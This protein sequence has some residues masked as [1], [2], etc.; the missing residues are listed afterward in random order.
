[1]Q[2]ILVLL[3]I[4]II[5]FLLIFKRTPADISG[6]VGWF[7][8]A[9]I[10]GLF[11]E[12]PILIILK[13][14]FSGILASLPIALVVATSILQVTI[15]QEA[16]AIDRVVAL[17]KTISPQ[18][19]TVQIMI[20]NIGF[21]TLL[22]ALGAVPVSILPPIMLAMGY[23][24]F[25]AIALP[26]LGYDALCTYA[27]LGIPV[28]VFSGFVGLPVQEAGMFFARFMPIIS[29]C[30][31]LG[32]L[33]IVGRWKLLLKGFLPAVLSGLTAGLIAIGMNKI[34]LV[35]LTGI[36]AG[37]GVI[38]IMILYLFLTKQPIRDRNALNDKDLA[39]EKKISL[40]AAISPWLALTFFSLIVNAPFLP[41]F[42]LFFVD[43]AM[44]I[45]IIPGEPEKIR[46][47]WQAYF[48]ILISTLL[49]LPFL[50]LSKEQLS[51]SITTWFKRFP[52]PMLSAAIFF[53]IAFV[54]N[55]SGK[56]MDWQ[57]L[58]PEN[59]MI[60]I[61]ADASA[62]TF[63]RLYPLAA[64]FLGL[65]GGFVSGSETSSIAML[66]PLHLSTAEKIKGA[67]ILI[68]AASGIGGGLASVISPAKLQNAAA[69]IDRIGEETSVISTTLGIALV[70]TLVC[71]VVTLIWA[72]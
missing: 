69:S 33:W 52:R 35:T 9:L 53:A 14:S 24:S 2:V 29:T 16:G 62:K 21:G 46:F 27:L 66:T 28:V 61:L 10:A 3:P 13:S 64:P 47:F 58:H 1:M 63:G 4:I 43:L 51:S 71:A 20:I 8:T 26:S 32:M 72:F 60:F 70:I 22:A 44:P 65:L 18:N 56:S 48:W 34:G 25:I 15:M 19:K 40:L 57:L 36:A 11:F 30:I 7:I 6:L 37:A 42:K 23:S 38:G 31:A 5:F 50:K 39:S 41:F 17:I 45:E 55:H 68:A 54:I 59:N 12:T 49:C 67:G